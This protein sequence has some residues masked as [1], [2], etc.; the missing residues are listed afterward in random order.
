MDYWAGTFGLV[1]F[2]LLETILFMWVY[3]SEKAFAEMN[4]GGDFKI[5]R[6]FLFIMK[7]ITPVFLLGIMIWW[8]ILDAIPTLLL[9]DIQKDK[10]PYIWGARILMIIL[11]TGII[12]MIKKAWNKKF[13]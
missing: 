3:G 2:A 12:L 8:M 10:I 11:S 9:K 6:M 4:E 7:Y 5:P 13:N 1:V